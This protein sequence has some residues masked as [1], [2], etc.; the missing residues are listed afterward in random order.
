MARLIDGKALAAALRE[1]VAGAAAQLRDRHG[2]VPGLAAV[3]VGDDPASQVYVKSK[4]RAC[5]EA[6]L[7]SDHPRAPRST[8]A[9]GANG[10]VA[11]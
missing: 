10:A 8:S 11:P 7:P 1:K 9:N 6:R 4:A 2:A 5:R 3:L